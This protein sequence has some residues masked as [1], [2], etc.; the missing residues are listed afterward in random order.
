M[1]KTIGAADKIILSSELGQIESLKKTIGRRAIGVVYDPAQL[2]RELCTFHHS[3][4]V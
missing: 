4:Q 1:S 3:K 2:T